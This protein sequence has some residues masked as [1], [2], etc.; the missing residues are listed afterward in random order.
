MAEVSTTPRPDRGAIRNELNETRDKFNALLNSLS[1]AEWKVKSA[2]PA[3]T[4][5]QVM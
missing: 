5:G 4:V 1:D 2:N 3:W